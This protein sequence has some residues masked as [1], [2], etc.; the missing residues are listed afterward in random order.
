M[1][2]NMLKLPETVKL[3]KWIND[4]KTKIFDTGMHA[5]E[6]AIAAS[7]QLGFTIVA[8]NVES[9]CDAFSIAIPTRRRAAK[10]D[11]VDTFARQQLAKLHEAINGSVPAELRQY[12]LADTV[13]P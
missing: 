10:S 2:R 8:K 9:T 11:Y 1:T 7:Q 4:N 13:A 6:I 3:S 5:E 12:L